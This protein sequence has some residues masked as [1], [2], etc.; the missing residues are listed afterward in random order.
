[1]RVR[2][3]LVTKE[4]RR[5]AKVLNFGVLYGMGILGFQRAA[6]V[7]RDEARLFIQN[8]MHEFQG[9][10]RYMEDTKALARRQG[11]VETVFGRR[12]LLPDINSTMPAVQAA[13]ERMAINMPVQ[14]TSA[15][16]IKLAMIEIQKLID[17]TYGDQAAMLLQV[18]DELLFEVKQDMVAE[19]TPQIVEIMQSVREF[20]VPI[21]VDAKVGA[22]WAEMEKL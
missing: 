22:N 21:V 17:A 20:K 11:W 14:G 6:G 12:R 18:H 10:A 8:Y 19:I 7:G 13:A 3:G 2:P 16:L 5:Q 15:D 4:M 9:L 1:F